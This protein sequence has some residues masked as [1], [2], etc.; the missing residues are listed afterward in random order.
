MLSLYYILL[1]PLELKNTKDGSCVLGS[2]CSEAAAALD[3]L[4]WVLKVVRTWGLERCSCTWATF[5]LGSH[6]VDDTFAE[7][8]ADGLLTSTPAWRT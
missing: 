3:V 4:D 6:D 2:E 5:L 1:K 7:N 8:R